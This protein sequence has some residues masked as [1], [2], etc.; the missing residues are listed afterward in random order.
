MAQTPL[1]PAGGGAV[2]VQAKMPDTDIA[3]LLRLAAQ[4]RMTR[5]A[6]TRQLVRLGLDVLELAEASSGDH[7]APA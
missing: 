5:S 7:G 4:R 6:M 3:R 1:N 2:R